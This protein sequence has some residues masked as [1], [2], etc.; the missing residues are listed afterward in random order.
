MPTNELILGQNA[1]EFDIQFAKTNVP[2]SATTPLTLQGGNT[3]VLIPAGYKFH[4]VAIIIQST[5]AITAQTLTAVVTDNGSQVAYGP[6]AVLD[7]T[8]QQQSGV[9]R[10]DE[11]PIQAGHL[12]GVSVITPGGFTPTTNGIDVT[13]MGFFTPYTAIQ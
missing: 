2:A 13:L 3:G 1:V 9:M 7:T 11:W 5:V 6:Q 12:V 8:Y 4:P 10:A